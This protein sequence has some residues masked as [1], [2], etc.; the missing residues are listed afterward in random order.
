MSEFYKI[1]Y[2]APNMKKVKAVL[3]KTIKGYHPVFIDEQVTLEIDP[4]KIISMESI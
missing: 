1:E 3:M 4:K 2:Y